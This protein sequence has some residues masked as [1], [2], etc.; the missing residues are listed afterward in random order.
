MKQWWSFCLL[1][2]LLVWSASSAEAYV[3]EKTDTGKM[4]WWKKQPVE[5]TI[6]A[7]GLGDYFSKNPKTGAVGSEFSAITASFLTWNSIQ[8]SGN[9]IGLN[10]QCIEYCSR[11]GKKR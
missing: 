11:S 10:F 7:N 2:C 4:L 6:D 3:R 9:P 8:C 5:F 1:V